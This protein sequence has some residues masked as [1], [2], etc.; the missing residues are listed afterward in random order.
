MFNSCSVG[1]N[2]ITAINLLSQLIKNIPSVKWWLYLHTDYDDFNT[3]PLT[4][5]IPA[6]DTDTTVRVAVTDDDIVEGNETFYMTLYVPSSLAPG[7]VAGTNSS[8]LGII[9]DSSGKTI[10]NWLSKF[11]LNDIM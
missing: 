5:T 2:Y 11:Y 10:V 3:T 6:G 4:A 9:I 7:V 8:A 1:D